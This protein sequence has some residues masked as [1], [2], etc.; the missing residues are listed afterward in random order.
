MRAHLLLAT[1][2]ACAAA[3]AA[4][5]LSAGQRCALSLQPLLTTRGACDIPSDSKICPNA[6]LAALADI[7]NVADEVRGSLW[8]YGSVG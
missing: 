2:A 8:L 5:N 4:I 6:C 7:K 1:L 3:A